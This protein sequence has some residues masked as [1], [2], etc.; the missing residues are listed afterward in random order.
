[1][2]GTT[3]LTPAFIEPI[4]AAERDRPAPYVQRPSARER[5]FERRLAER[6]LRRRGRQA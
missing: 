4:T 3:D 5:R 1:M 6:R 2:T